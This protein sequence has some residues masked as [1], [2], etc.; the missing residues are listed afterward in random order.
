MNMNASAVEGGRERAIYFLSSPNARVN[1]MSSTLSTDHGPS[2]LPLSTSHLFT[3]T[4]ILRVIYHTNQIPMVVVQCRPQYIVLEML[5]KL[6]ESRTSGGR[7]G[8][9][10]IVGTSHWTGMGR[11]GARS[12]S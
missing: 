8:R 7:L 9:L 1:N 3:F 4:V 11:V 10:G 2:R 5:R 6:R 12:R